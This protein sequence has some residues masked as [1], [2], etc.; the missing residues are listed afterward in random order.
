MVRIR[1]LHGLW[2]AAAIAASV[3]A[4]TGEDSDA[5]PPAVEPLA[6]VARL[7]R[8]SMAVRGIPASLDEIRSIQQDPDALTGLVEGWL[9]SEAFGDT[10]EDLH[11][12]LYLLRADTNYQLPV[13]GPLE[14]RGYDQADV[15]FSTVSAPT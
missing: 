11:A 15:H 12:E 1:T 10:V 7:K 8:A 14:E 4:C 9:G 3:G 6:D 5:P 13:M 2:C